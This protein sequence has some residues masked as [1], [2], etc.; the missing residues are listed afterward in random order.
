MA[1]WR[2]YANLIP[3]RTKL[4]GTRQACTNMAKIRIEMIERADGGEHDG[5][6]TAHHTVSPLID[7]FK[8]DGGGQLGD[9]SCNRLGVI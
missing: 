3:D 9:C 2:E 1:A 8:L 6:F 4:V 5:I 7:A